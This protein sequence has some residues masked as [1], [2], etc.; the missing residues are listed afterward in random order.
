MKVF[1]AQYTGWCAGCGEYYNYDTLVTYDHGRIVH[2]NCISLSEDD[3]QD[4]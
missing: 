3:E 2:D 4:V 1:A